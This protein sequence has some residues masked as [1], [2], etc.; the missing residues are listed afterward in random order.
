MQRVVM[1]YSCLLLIIAPEKVLKRLPLRALFYSGPHPHFNRSLT[2]STNDSVEKI[3]SFD[4]PTETISAP[5]LDGNSNST[6]PGTNTTFGQ[7]GLKP[8]PPSI[9]LSVKRTDIPFFDA[10]CEAH[11]LS[12]PVTFHDFSTVCTLFF[13][14]RLTITS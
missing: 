5:P 10:Y 14:H 9:V 11:G 3:F 12:T 4:D 13:S 2:M 6:I 7:T 1:K 8:L